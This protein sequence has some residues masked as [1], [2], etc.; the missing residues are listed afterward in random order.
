MKPHLLLA[1]AGLLL[2]FRFVFSAFAAA[3]PAFT[4]AAAQAMIEAFLRHD[5][6][7]LDA[8]F[9]DG[10]T[11][12]QQ[13]EARRP[14]LRQQYLEMLG[15]W[16]LPERTPHQAQ[17]TGV[18]EREEGFRVEKLHFQSRPR[19]YVTGNLYLPKDAKPG[20]KLPAVLYVCGHSG[21]GRDG[22]KTAFQ[23]HGMWF[24]THGYACL[25]IDT[26]QLG[27]IAGI[28]HGTYRYDRWWW[29][30]RGYTPA[31]VE[32]WNGLRALDYL[33]SRPEVDPERLAVT[34][35]SGGGAASFWIAAADERVKVAVPVSGMGDLEDYVGEKVVNGHCD[36]MFLINTF[37]WPWT[38]IAALVAP[39]PLLFENSGHDPIFPMNGNDHIRARLERLYGFYTNRTERLFDIGITPGGHSDNPELRLMAYRWINWHFKGSNAPVTEPALPTFEGK[40]LRAFP[41]EL[42]ADELNTKIDELFVPMAT[43]ALPSTTE[44]FKAWRDGR[45]AELRRIVFRPLPK[46]FD[47]Q[48]ALA[49]GSKPAE[50]SVT[51]APDILTHWKYFP[52]PRGKSDAPRWLVVLGE[53]DSLDAKPDWVTKLA[54]DA[55]VLLVAPRGTGPTRWADPAPFY[56]RRSLALLG[57]TID[58]GRM[59]DVLAVAARAL[60]ARSSPRSKWIIA[61]RGQTGVIAAYAALF[62]PRLAE[63]VLVDPPASHRDS[64]IF[65]NVLRVLDVP[66]AL[67]LLAP[68][69]LTLHTRQPEIFDR[70][71]QIHRV[72]GGTFRT[73]TPL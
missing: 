72:A 15:L 27:E 42:P 45:I 66:D 47:P 58:E 38:Q 59:E 39:R 64:P 16:P 49:L 36:C 37:Q 40:Q 6:V 12:R 24:A 69:S 53:D 70:T 61:G 48:P 4:N 41:E 10:I 13:W 7:R 35:I 14:E 18:L 11:N 50:G 62:E 65:L 46:Q 55:P 73:A 33:Q 56:V 25:L 17:V 3:P 32:C 51:S 60:P 54:G 67:G 1:L 52:A 2:S 31:G 9:L 28:H 30:A 8:Q 44:E 5:A 20:A 43:N 26:L 63:V 71:A 19:L 57:R 29:Q 68:R 22:N 23:H 34:G 21:R